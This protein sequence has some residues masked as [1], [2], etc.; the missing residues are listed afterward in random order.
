[1]RLITL[2]KGCVIEQGGDEKL[3]RQAIVGLNEN[4]VLASCKSFV[5]LENFVEV[6]NIRQ[7]SSSH[8]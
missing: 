8:V 6:I 2:G 5:L 7:S 3:K 4:L 1:M